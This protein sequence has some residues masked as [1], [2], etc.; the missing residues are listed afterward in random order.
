MGLFLSVH[1]TNLVSVGFLSI[2]DAPAFSSPSPP[3]HSFYREPL[4]TE[5]GCPSHSLANC[6]RSRYVVQIRC[7]PTKTTT[8]VMMQL[9]KSSFFND[10]C[11]KPLY[12]NLVTSLYFC[13]LNIK[14]RNYIINKYK[15]SSIYR[16]KHL[17]SIIK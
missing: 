14:I 13:D 2:K 5:V 7:L 10:L 1:R 15:I 4:R 9:R 11:C 8:I 6:P 3:T 16:K 17:S 12:S